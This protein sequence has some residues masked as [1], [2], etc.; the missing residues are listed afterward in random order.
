MAPDRPLSRT[1]RTR[2]G[3]VFHHLASLSA[4]STPAIAVLALVLLGWESAL[5]AV[6]VGWLLLVPLFTIAQSV[7]TPDPLERIAESVG[8]AVAS[9]IENRVSIDP[10]GEARGATEPLETLRDRYAAGEID[11]AAFERRV[12]RL[13]ETDLEEPVDQRTSPTLHERPRQDERRRVR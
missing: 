12:E 6:T 10:D 2:L 4:V 3:V 11:E 7:V 8:I 1:A 5:V 9:T 13:L